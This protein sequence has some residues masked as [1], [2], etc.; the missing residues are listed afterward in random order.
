[1]AALYVPLPLDAQLL[2]LAQVTPKAASALS[3]Q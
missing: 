2:L 1:M 3:L